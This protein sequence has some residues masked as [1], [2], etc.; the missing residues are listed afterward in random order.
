MSEHE[1]TFNVLPREYKVLPATLV[2]AM[3]ERIADGSYWT[4]LR[5]DEDISLK[6]LKVVP[7]GILPT[8]Q[9]AADREESEAASREEFSVTM[10]GGH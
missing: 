3:P 1:G 4:C 5:C 2:S 6:R 7:G 10:I 8:C 9:E